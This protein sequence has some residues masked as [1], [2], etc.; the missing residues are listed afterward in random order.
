MT[1]PLL[2]VL[3]AALVA[4]AVYRIRSQQRLPDYR[5][6]WASSDRPDYKP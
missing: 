2:V 6:D 3:A 5:P 1:R 4:L